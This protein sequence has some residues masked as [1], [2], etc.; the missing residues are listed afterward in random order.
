[1][2]SGRQAGHNHMHFVEHRQNRENGF[3]CAA[4]KLQQTISKDSNDFEKN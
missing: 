1:L 4:E 2:N 3:S